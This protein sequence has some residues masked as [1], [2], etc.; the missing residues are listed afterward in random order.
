MDKK[1]SNKR[2]EERWKLR[3]KNARDKGGEEKPFIN[4]DD[5]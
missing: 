1:E 5:E 2:K 3:N 4:P